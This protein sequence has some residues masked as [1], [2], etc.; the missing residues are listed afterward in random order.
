MIAINIKKVFIVFKTHF[1]IGYTNLA[2]ELLEWYGGSMIRD[3]VEVCEATSNY[4]EGKKYIWT[5]PSWPLKKAMEKIREPELKERAEKLVREGQLI[6]HGLPFTTH[7]ESCGLEEFIR[8]LYIAGELS[9]KY[10]RWTSDA[11]MT[12]VPGHTWM[13]PSI[14]VKAGIKFIHLGSNICAAT[15]DVPRLFF[16]EGPDGS[17]VLTYYSKDYGTELVPPDDWD[18]PYWLAMLQTADNQGVQNAG[19]LEEMF[20]RVNRELPDVEVVIGSL[21]DF[22]TAMLESGCDIPIVKGDMAD[23]WIRGV[24]SAPGGVSRL[25]R[26]ESVLP[27]IE[28]MA[29]IYNIAGL[30]KAMDKEKETEIHNSMAGCY[31]KLLLFGEHTWSMDTKATIL[32]ERHWGSS[33]NGFKFWENGFYNKEI[34]DSLRKNDPG[35]LKL[36]ESWQEQLEYLNHAEKQ[37]KVLMEDVV[38]SLAGS[39]AV[40]GDKLI[41]C[42]N[43]GW[44]A[45]LSVV[46]E[47]VLPLDTRYLLDISTDTKIPIYLNHEGKRTADVRT[48]SLGYKTFKIL[49]G[50]SGCNLPERK[51][52]TARLENTDGILEN[53]YFRIE[54]DKVSGCIRKFYQKANGKE[55]VD[56]SSG[57]GFGQYVYDIYG[58][59]E[60]NGYLADYCAV[61]RDWAV[62][63]MGKAGYPKDQPH[64]R[65]VP[66][67]FDILCENGYNWGKITIT[68]GITDESHLKYGNAAEFKTSII[69]YEDREYVDISY[70]LTG[71]SETPMIESGHFV[72]PLAVDN[73]QYSINKLGAV[74]DPETDILPGC[75][76]DLHCM[77]KWMDVSNEEHGMAVIAIDMPLFSFNEPGVLKYDRDFKIKGPLV[78]FQ[79]F[80]NTWGTNFPQWI[81]GNLRFRYR[82]IPHE[83]GRNI[84]RIGRL[85]EEAFMK[86]VCAYADASEKQGGLPTA[87]DILARELKGFAILSF[88]A[89]EDGKGVVLRLIEMEGKEREAKITFDLN[90]DSVWKCDLMERQRERIAVSHEDGLSSITFNT[91]QFEIHT[92]YLKNK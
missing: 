40:E 90:L 27:V 37:V 14:L 69:A 6:W 26:L 17:R 42:G 11:K 23:T 36:Q 85:A 52:E 1:D 82:F 70:E 72:F 78:W 39:V 33:W 59:R 79:A 30:S 55:W 24:G 22:G 41:I 15:P 43:L 74:I 61:L 48:A 73:P 4:P 18:Y 77:G 7:T 63:D 88:K 87:V 45:E 51:Q 47:D 83:G 80:N 91:C 56:S 32:P 21:E 9:E 28:S 50:T 81:G 67:R 84:G 34:F 62:N 35:Y 3:A 57:H 75:N 44:K 16:W 71:K 66:D 8:G 60:L 65:F 12:D 46:L 20:A 86:Q 68:T 64:L 31:E 13:L 49:D 92:F 5:V 29:V 58:S 38:A 76:K 10:G 89:S 19:F 2:G 25:R 54:I 53:R